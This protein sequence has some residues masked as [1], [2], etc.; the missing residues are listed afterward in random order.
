MLTST[1]ATSGGTSSKVFLPG[2]A[3]VTDLCRCVFVGY[4]WCSRSI[5]PEFVSPWTRID[6]RALYRLFLSPDGS[7]RVSSNGEVDVRGVYCL[8]AVAKLLNMMTEEL[9]RGTKEWVKGCQTYEGE[10]Q[11]KSSDL[12]ALGGHNIY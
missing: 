3:F 11:T 10:S 1:L 7:F 6:R 2:S 9:V 5:I 12:K 4:C 8:L